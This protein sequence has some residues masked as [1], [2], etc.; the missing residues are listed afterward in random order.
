MDE[1]QN[2]LFH[3]LVLL[4]AAIESSCCFIVQGE[5]TRYFPLLICNLE[6]LSTNAFRSGATLG[7]GMAR[8]HVRIL[9]T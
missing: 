2:K 7:E 5:E 8:I 9:R 6:T 3:F 4:H 1:N